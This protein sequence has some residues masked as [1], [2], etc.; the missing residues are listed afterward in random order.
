MGKNQDQRREQDVI[1]AKV[2]LEEQWAYDRRMERLSFRQMRELAALP[3]ERGG[4][5]YAIPESTLKHRA[6]AYFARV[7]A[8]L[9]T[10]VDER[11]ARQE[12][13]I[14]ELI[15]LAVGDIARARAAG[16]VKASAEA[17]ARLLRYQEREAK[18][19]GTDAP[20]QIHQ[21]VETRDGLLDDLNASLI[22]LGREP[23]TSERP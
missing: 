11:R 12:A 20:Q 9:R 23:V 19:F 1:L 22:A 15:R 14:D 2:T 5:G 17:E 10:G 21:T 3:V 18:I 4:L 13:E 16:D 8:T 7:K 6:D